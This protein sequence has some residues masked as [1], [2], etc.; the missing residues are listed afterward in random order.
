[1]VGALCNMVTWWASNTRTVLTAPGWLMMVT[2]FILV[3]AAAAVKHRVQLKIHTLDLRSSRSCHNWSFEELKNRK[4]QPK[5]SR[6][7]YKIVRVSLCY[8]WWNKRFE[9][10]F[11]KSKSKSKSFSQWMIGTN[12]VFKLSVRYVQVYP[13]QTQLSGSFYHQIYSR[14]LYA[15]N[16]PKRHEC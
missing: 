16:G 9:L 7:N 6:R 1:M 3:A 8:Y 14:K 13:P 15:E 10:S 5:D 11:G 2:G 4:P 12:H